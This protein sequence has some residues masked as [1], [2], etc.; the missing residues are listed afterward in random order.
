MNQYRCETCKNIDCDCNPIT[1]KG[2]FIPL[3]DIRKF[4]A[5]KGCASHSD[6]NPQAERERVLD[7]LKK[8]PLMFVKSD[9][10]LKTAQ[11]YMVKCQEKFQRENPCPKCGSHNTDIDLFTPMF[12]LDCGYKWFPEEL[13]QR[14]DGE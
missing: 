10:A 12:C 11:A 7:E 4:T 14:K 13:R 3:L 2:Y 6:F 5:I 9:P 8:E 1:Q